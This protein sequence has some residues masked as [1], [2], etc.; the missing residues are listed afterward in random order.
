MSPQEAVHLDAWL[1][2][3]VHES[4]RDATLDA[5]LA[6]LVEYPELPQTRT[7]PE[8]R[9]LAERYAESARKEGR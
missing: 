9:S 8:I 2:R 5:M 7:W 6:F 3:T 1:T 4:E